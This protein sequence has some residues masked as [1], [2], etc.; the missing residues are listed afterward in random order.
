MDKTTKSQIVSARIYHGSYDPRAI[1]VSV[2][3]WGVEIRT[4]EEFYSDLDKGIL[5]KIGGELFPGCQF[6]FKTPGS[7]VMVPVIAVPEEND[8]GQGVIVR[9]L[10]PDGHEVDHAHLTEAVLKESP[11]H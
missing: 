7:T 2:A 11:I 8:H 10:G 9:L 4:L 1:I 6:Y 3:S 5:V